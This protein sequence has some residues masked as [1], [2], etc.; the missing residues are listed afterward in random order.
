MKV[1]K[2]ILERYSKLSTKK[3]ILEN[4]EPAVT[5]VNPIQ[6]SSTW[7]KETKWSESAELRVQA[8]DHIKK[9]AESEDAEAVKFMEYLDKCT[10]NYGTEQTLPVAQVESE[11]EEDEEKEI[12]ESDDEEDE[13]ELDESDDEEEEELDEE[14]SE[15][16]EEELDESEEEESEE[17]EL[18]EEESEDEESEEDEL[19]E[20]EDEESE[21]EKEVAQNKEEAK[22]ASKVVS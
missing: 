17:E 10:E 4:E 2:S 7:L 18:D 12:E 3:V 13:E 5:V 6:E 8:A 21:D 11:E 22:N 15:E 20:E 9:I 16:D 1:A 19:D 14:E